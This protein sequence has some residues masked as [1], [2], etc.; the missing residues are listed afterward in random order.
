[1][2][3]GAES[4]ELNHLGFFYLLLYNLIFIL[5]MLVIT[6]M[7]GTGYTS[8]E[9]I[10][11]FKNKHTKLIHLIVGLLMLALGAYIIGSMYL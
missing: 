10:G 1:M 7:V 4:S 3:L 2:L 8:A 6:F 9:A 11:K 5:P